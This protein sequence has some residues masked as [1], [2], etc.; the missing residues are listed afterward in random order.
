MLRFKSSKTVNSL[1]RRPNIVACGSGAFNILHACSGELR[2]TASLFAIDKQTSSAGMHRLCAN[3]IRMSIISI[4]ESDAGHQQ[5][6]K[7]D[8]AELSEALIAGEAP[9]IAYVCLGRPTGSAGAAAVAEICSRS[10][11][12]LHIIATQPFSREPNRFHDTVKSDINRLVGSADTFTL[13]GNEWLVRRV[14][15]KVAI[16]DAFDLVE[17][18]FLRQTRLILELET[19]LAEQYRH[20]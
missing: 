12:P 13:V 7:A 9:V 19:Q 4:Y 5:A 6:N 14:G 8:V 18:A 15:P 16:R 17:Q 10:N 3:D 20:P 11:L 2:D 1:G